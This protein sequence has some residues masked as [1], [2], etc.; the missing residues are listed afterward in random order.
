MSLFNLDTEIPFEAY[1]RTIYHHAYSYTHRMRDP[2]QIFRISK[3]VFN[4]A[5]Q[6]FYNGKF[7][8]ALYFALR[9]VALLDH[10]ETSIDVRKHDKGARLFIKEV[11]NFVENILSGS[12]LNK[13]Y[14][15]MIKKIRDN[16]P[17][18]KKMI[19]LQMETDTSMTL[20][21]N[22]SLHNLRRDQLLDNECEKL[23][24]FRNKLFGLNSLTNSSQLQTSIEDS[25][26]LSQ[27]TTVVP[28][29]NN[30][31]EKGN[32]SNV[33]YSLPTGLTET[34]IHPLNSRP[35]LYKWS[36]NASKDSSAKGRG[37]VNIG[38]SCY[39]NSVL[40]VINVTPLA[41]FFL[42][43]D[44]MELF[45]NVDNKIV[46]VVNAFAFIIRELFHTET[47][48]A[49]SAS[50][51]KGAIGVVCETFDNKIQ[52]DAN[53][54]LRILLDMLHSGLNENEGK[55]VKFSEIDN[56]KGTDEELSRKY[57]WQYSQKNS[58]IIT[59]LCAFQERSCITCPL[60]DMSSRSFQ[61]TLGV[62]LPI[63]EG[64]TV[65]VEDC[66]NAYCAKELLSNDSLYLCPKC[67]KKVNA[68]KQ[69]SFFS[70][71]EVLFITLKRFRKYGDFSNL[72]KI[73]SEVFFQ[74]SLDLSPFI[75]S[76]F[77]KTK[78][79]LAGII[80]HQGNVH[81]GHY[82][83]DTIGNDNIWFNFSDERVTVANNPDFRQAYILC[84][85]RN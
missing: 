23:H 42:Q 49:I 67:N 84:Y 22:R 19:A 47:S 80:N 75:S 4:R 6:E 51:L 2:A 77:S 28:E 25:S 54:F 73:N 44:Y 59:T 43:D 10:K 53:E 17:A 27:T 13:Q 5:K 69:L 70:T 34:C 11:M 74:R 82:T 71:P 37:I 61:T 39:M 7:D 38:N 76:N 85:L 68:T 48:F 31:F 14:Q 52:Q 16:E 36:F 8:M 57:W 3:L 21:D 66:L 12:E 45:S 15:E 29:E 41:K 64:N 1:K 24:E 18:R 40:Q 83:S 46:R 33:E 81:G 20:E 9:T 58:S 32:I 65:S 55:I 50:T 79:S 78:F 35:V 63:I 60:C 72:A 56:C 26:T 62:E 30:I